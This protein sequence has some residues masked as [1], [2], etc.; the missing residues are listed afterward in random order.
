MTV[1]TEIDSEE[2]TGNGVT[3]SFPYRFRILQQS[4]MVVTQIDLNDV[5]TVLVLGTDYTITGAGGY[6]GGN[7]ILPT[8]LANGYGLTLVRD[9]PITQET[10]L[11]NQGTFF[12]ETH[13]DAFD[14]LTMLIQQVWGWFGLAL[15]RNT[16]L[17]KYY[18]AKGYRIGNLGDPVNPQDAVT[19]SYVDEQGSLSISKTIRV[20]ESFIPELPNI[21][22]RANKI[23]TF[24]PT[25]NPLATVPV[26][27]SAADVLI[28]LAKPNGS[29]LIGVGQS[30]LQSALY[31]GFPE[32]YGAVGDGVVDDKIAL[33][34]CFN[35]HAVT[36]LSAKT[37]ASSGEL[38]VTPGHSV[39]GCGK[40]KSI[41]LKIGAASGFFF[42]ILG[43][44]GTGYSGFAEDFQVDVK[45]LVEWAMYFGGD[46]TAT[47]SKGRFSGIK[48]RDGVKGNAILD[49][50]QNS[51]FIDFDSANRTTFSGMRGFYLINGAGNNFIAN[52]EMSGGSEGSLVMGRDSGFPCWSLNAF[53]RI[54]SNNTIIQC[55]ME[56]ISETSVLAQRKRAM[57]LEY[58][59]HN[60]IISSDI[61]CHGSYSLSGVLISDTCSYN[62]IITCNVGNNPSGTIPAIINN[63]YFTRVDGGSIIGFTGASHITTTQP[64]MVSSSTLVDSGLRPKIT[65]LAGDTMANIGG[66]VDYSS[67][68][69][70]NLPSFTS[71][72]RLVSD[73]DSRIFLSRQT[74]DF[75]QVRTGYQRTLY[76]AAVTLAVNGDH[77]TC[78][79]GFG[80][81]SGYAYRLKVAV[82][83]GTDSSHRAYFEAR[84]VFN[85]GVQIF[86][87]YKITDTMV[88][89]PT[90][91]V[92]Y[93][94]TIFMGTDG[95]VQISIDFA[96]SMTVASARVDAYS[97]GFVG[98]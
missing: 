37:Y 5:E 61:V 86:R 89:T 65:N 13:E 69:G 32:M 47:I 75:L 21:N 55:I 42:K 23:L 96:S 79:F 11:R 17:S 8:P 50:V 39:K 63:G 19:K 58:S 16:S 12:A 93:N 66:N 70:T 81:P 35:N 98:F 73:A 57:L 97:E 24:G 74:S 54:N 71:P 90:A 27:G 80:V 10:D 6:S 44:N 15:R 60:K 18:D 45:G 4:D 64:I 28:Q 33:Q 9:L 41:I 88:T 48:I 78:T 56:S 29:S 1:S 95:L 43:Q 7:V 91:G 84:V 22:G 2:Y 31:Y 46:A 83:S 72:N 62:T 94:P 82:K 51:T 59:D 87:D 67:T 38:S 34:T 68:S 52:I 3:T 36:I 77:K 49:A 92:I 25:G 76:N 14:K 53:S 20:P 26:S 30:T 85:N 40:D